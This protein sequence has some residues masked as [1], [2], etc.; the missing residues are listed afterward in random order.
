[1]KQIDDRVPN[2]GNIRVSPFLSIYVSLVLPTRSFTRRYGR[3]LWPH[4]TL[5]ANVTG[6]R[7][8]GE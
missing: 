1:M 2:R 7:R 4:K 6:D 8:D 5:K 3:Y